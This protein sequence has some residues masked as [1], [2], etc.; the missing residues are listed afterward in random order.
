MAMNNLGN[1]YFALGRNAEALKLR[2]ETAALYKTKLGPDHPDTLRSMGNLASSY[3]SVGRE[4]DALKLRE[5]VLALR[6]AK[7]G[8]D[9]PSTLISMSA[10]GDSYEN[11][12]RHADALKIRQ[13]NLALRK[14]KLGP[15]H[16]DTLFSMNNV[17]ESYAA[18]GRD[19]EALKL[20]EETYPLRRAKL[21]AD[22]P[23]TLLTM[24]ELAESLV[25]ANRIQ[26]ATPMVDECLRR[27]AGKN[28]D[29]SV[30]FSAYDA[31]LRICEK[32]KDAAGCRQAA[33]SWEK[34]NR[35]DPDSLYS[36]ACFRAITAS[37]LRA[38][39][40]SPGTNRPADDEA[41][42]AMDWLKQAVTA[43]FKNAAHMK[44]DKDLDAVRGRD[45]FK[46]LMAEL[47]G[48]K[49]PPGH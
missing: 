21:G 28:L 23:D 15:D 29:A 20:R 41:D 49:A 48:A 16:P 7:L 2:E 25:A 38:A 44:Q 10:L 18:L 24:A 12:G 22:H 6:R 34:L 37:V 39:D 13:E 32:A 5:E 40:K 4:A 14:A 46:K 47:E 3:A 31:R 9:H 19:A 33:E 35:T 45:D 27:A 36:A 43:G 17:A 26:E 8:P 11:L 30:L 42:R 1:A